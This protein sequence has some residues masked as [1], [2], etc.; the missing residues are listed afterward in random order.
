MQAALSHRLDKQSMFVIPLT[1]DPTPNTSSTE[2]IQTI[3]ERFGVVVALKND[4]RQIDRTGILAAD[5]LHDIRGSLFKILIGWLLPDAKSM[6]S[7]AGGR[8]LDMNPAWMWYQF[9]FTY[10]STLSMDELE[11]HDAESQTAQIYEAAT[12]LAKLGAGL[13]V[14]DKYN[15]KTALQILEEMSQSP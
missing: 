12:E 8:L 2:V 11:E 14:G 15:G 4:L 10:D 1:D 13:Q 7:Y 3:N 6:M 9:E 5:Q